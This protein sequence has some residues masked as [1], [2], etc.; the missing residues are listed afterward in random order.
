[1]SLALTRGVNL[2]WLSEQTGVAA[3]TLLK[4][5]GKFIHTLDADRA[6]LSKIEG[7][8]GTDC[9]RR[10]GRKLNPLESLAAG[11]VPDGI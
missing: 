11:S 2:A 1:V 6:E 10:R 5:Y 3:T 9:P 4:H 8:S 7:E